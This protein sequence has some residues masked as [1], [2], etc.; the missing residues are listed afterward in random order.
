MRIV[1]KSDCVPLKLQ[2]KT[3]FF[4]FIHMPTNS[5]TAPRE[6]ALTPHVLH[7]AF[8]GESQKNR[9]KYLHKLK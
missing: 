8:Q 2:E 1:L 7:L 9:K 4:C 3:G 6:I 5:S